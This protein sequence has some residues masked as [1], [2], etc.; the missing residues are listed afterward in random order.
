M[1]KQKALEFKNT[2][3]E[4]LES[5]ERLSA[6]IA[7]EINNPLGLILG[8]TQLLLKEAE[9]G[10]PFHE[11][12][13]M[14]EKHAVNCKN[15]LEDL[16]SFSRSAETVKSLV[17]LNDLVNEVLS[18]V[19]P[20][21]D[22]KRILI[23]RNLFSDPIHLK[24]DSEKVKQAFMN[25]LINSEQAMDGEGTVSIKTNIDDAAKSAEIS[26]KDTG[27]GIDPEIIHKIF[28]PFFTTR[29]SGMG[30]GLGLAV[31]Y[32]IVRDHEGEIRVSTALGKGSL[33]TVVFPLEGSNGREK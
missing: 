2:H 23:L 18:L 31:A 25:I 20:R 28:D 33:F 17:N 9:P 12:L 10:D 3:A 6:G 30:N 15:I 27:H 24:V 26:F 8:Y 13:K 22:A 4:R 14:V 11:D 16:L 29:P 5:L 21:F 7:H 1:D 19:Q 32:G